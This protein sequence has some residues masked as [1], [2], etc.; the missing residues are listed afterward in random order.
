M[1]IFIIVLFL[2]LQVLVQILQ[3]FIMDV[4]LM[5]VIITHRTR[6]IVCSMYLSECIDD[7]FISIKHKITKITYPGKCSL[8]KYEFID[9]HGNVIIFLY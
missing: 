8:R 2:C 9:A 1:F 6:N 3:I 5:F 4:V 7:H